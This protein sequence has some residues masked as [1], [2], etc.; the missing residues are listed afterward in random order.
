MSVDYKVRQIYNV[1]IKEVTETQESWKSVLRLAGQIYRYE[2]DNVLM[3]YAQK[4]HAT[5]VA[6]FDTW[7]KVG[8]YVKRGS[9]GIAIYPSRALQPY[10]RYV[11]DISDTGGKQS[12]LTW[13]LDGDKLP[14]FMEYQVAHGKYQKY[15]GVTR[16]DSLIA[17][18]DFTKREIGVIIEEEFENRMTELSQIT[19]S[20]IK[21]FSEKREGL[22]EV[23]D[24]AELAR[25]GI[26][27]VVGTRCGFDLSAEEQDFSQIVKVT[28]EDTIYRLGSLI[29]DVSCNVLRAFS[30]D[31]RTIENQ[32]SLGFSGAVPMSAKLTNSD[33]GTGNPPE[34]TILRNEE[35]ERRIAYGSRTRVQGSGWTSVSG[36]GDS[37][38]EG[39][40]SETGQIRTSGDEVSGGER[41]GEIQESASH[42]Q[43]DREDVRSGGRSES[44][45]GA[46]SESVSNKEQTTESKQY[47]GNVEVERTGE[48]DGR[49][50]RSGGDRPEISLNDNSYDEEL[51][52]EL[53]EINSLGVSKEA[54][55][56]VQASFFDAEYGLVDSAKKSQ[57][58]PNEY[59]QKFQQEIADAKSG[60]YN[61]LNPKKASV[62]PSEYVKEVVLRGTGFVGGRGRVC[63]IFETEIDAGTR[64]KRIKAEYGIG[65][66]GWPIEGLG[67]HGYDTFKGHGIRFQWRDEEGEVEGYVSWRDIEKEISA[68]ILTG[69]YQPEKPRL[70]EIQSDGMREDDEIIDA[71]F[72]EVDDEEQEEV[73]DEFAIPDEPE[74]YASARKSLEDAY[75]EERELTPEEAALEDRLVTMAEYGAELEAEADYEPT[76]DPTQKTSGELQ[77]IEPINYAEVIEGMDEDMRTAMEILISECSCYTPFKPFLMDLVATND[78]FMPNKLDYLSAVVLH[79][80]QEH[81]AYANNEY[82]LVEYTLK[83]FEIDINYKNKKGERV[84]ASTG[85]RELYEVL[86]Y[87]VKV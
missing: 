30:K 39:E 9:K 13:N 42:G 24:L 14:E 12:E 75:A 65:G 51:N 70:D 37:G 55:E 25:K 67:L 34:A 6:D 79:D 48:D 15:E 73:L 76:P 7:K 69:E 87:M 21:E 68:L 86:S 72:R 17:L 54:G 19:G 84:T 16:E 47:D 31:C 11:F 82:G 5:L 45:D 41:T 81:K 64:A 43:N 59:M 78:L 71:D 3:V 53:N 56:Y 29:C 36:T 62:V 57:A 32:K 85:Y 26:L 2:F 18:K 27:Y 58:E 61:Y 50:N 63:K 8:R 74:S 80:R 38:R 35:L 44:D 52:R 23:P 10:M 77:F 60:K 33:G 49:G 46:A 1:V 4:P 28:D 83:P 22:Q 20:V 66:S 40:L